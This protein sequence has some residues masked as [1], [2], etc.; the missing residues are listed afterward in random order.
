[1]QLTFAFENIANILTR[2]DVGLAL[3]V[4]R[5]DSKTERGRLG[6]REIAAWLRKKAPE[7][8]LIM[9]SLA[10]SRTS[11]ARDLTSNAMKMAR[12]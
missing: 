4:R 11:A 8:Y 12:I 6:K 9:S 3:M 10:A 5:A 7:A 1:M 2:R